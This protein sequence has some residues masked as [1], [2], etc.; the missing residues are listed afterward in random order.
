VT[1]TEKNSTQP[2][3]VMNNRYAAP[4]TIVQ[5]HAYKVR[6]SSCQGYAARG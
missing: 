5:T 1:T 6:S 3:N 4:G 2:V